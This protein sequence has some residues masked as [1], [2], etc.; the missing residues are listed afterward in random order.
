MSVEV[1]NVWCSP[2][3]SPTMEVIYLKR[4]LLHSC[5]SNA[6]SFSVIIIPLRGPQLWQIK[7]RWFFLW[8]RLR[9]IICIPSQ[10]LRLGLNFTDPTHQRGSQLTQTTSS[11]QPAGVEDSM[12]VPS[13]T[14]ALQAWGVALG[15]NGLISSTTYWVNLDHC[16]KR[17]GSLAIL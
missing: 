1:F 13:V 5:K 3:K 15:A 11:L 17:F 16:S 7:P 8:S 14:A 12:A 6:V 4:P 9:T 2:K 10:S